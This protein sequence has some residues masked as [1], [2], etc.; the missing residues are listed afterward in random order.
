VPPEASLQACKAAITKVSAYF[1]TVW[2]WIPR[3]LAP[4]ERDTLDGLCRSFGYRPALRS[5][6]TNRWMWARGHRVRLVLQGPSADALRFL[7]RRV[8]E[9]PA[10]WVNHVACA[11]DFQTS[12]TEE[13]EAV[14]TFIDAHLYKPNH[15]PEHGVVIYA[16]SITYLGF[17]NRCY[18]IAT[19]ADKPSRQ[20]G[21]PCAHIECRFQSAQTVRA[22]GIGSV[23]DLLAFSHRKFW[24]ARL[25]LYSY[26]L[27]R[28]GRR[29]NG[30]RLDRGAKAKASGRFTY[31]AD[32]R[33]GATL[34]RLLAR[35]DREKPILMDLLTFARKWRRS[36][37][38]VLVPLSNA[39]LIG[40]LPETAS[41]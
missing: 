10:P 17:K 41:E 7:E 26:D 15:R 21:M 22:L 18:R 16:D 12:T 25:R 11:L 32:Q 4:W 5:A 2:V 6:E 36:L 9:S 29:W 33:G 19:Y 3:T 34:A 13:A 37:D 38:R 27:E 24:E 40:E 8:M 14:R 35:G 39:E 1:D 31:N 20:T 23:A 30:K 28:L